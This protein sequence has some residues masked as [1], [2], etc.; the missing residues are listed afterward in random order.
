MPLSDVDREVW[1]NQVTM[2]VVLCKNLYGFK[3]SST[4]PWI[5]IINAM[6]MR[7]GTIYTEE[8]G[9]EETLE[10]LERTSG[11]V[12]AASCRYVTLRM[13]NP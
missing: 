7:T 2:W 13:L 11:R 9:T 4:S 5:Q 3:C 6:A 1:K 8:L 10:K 12:V